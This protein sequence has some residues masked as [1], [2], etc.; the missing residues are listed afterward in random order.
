AKGDSLIELGAEE[1]VS[2]F[3]GP[4]SDKVVGINEGADQGPSA[5]DEENAW[6]ADL[7]DVEPSEFEKLKSYGDKASDYC[8]NFLNIIKRNL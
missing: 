3:S 2:A 8:Y 7:A 5:L 6:S 4:L 1:A